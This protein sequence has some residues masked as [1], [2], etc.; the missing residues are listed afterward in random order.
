AAD[1]DAADPDAADP[2]AA[3][4][5]A[6]DPDAADPDAADPDAV[7]AA[8]PHAARTDAVDET[9]P[10]QPDAVDPD[11]ANA[12]APSPADSLG[13]R[14]RSVADHATHE[15]HTDDTN[16]A[17]HA[18]HANYADDPVA[19]Q[20]FGP[21]AASRPRAGFRRWAVASAIVVVLA[22]AVLVV[23]GAFGQ[24]TTPAEPEVAVP[25]RPDAAAA[26]DASIGK[27]QERLRRLPKDYVTWASLG[28]AYIEKA[29]IT[30]D[31][32]WYPKA[33]GALKQSLAVRPSP[34]AAAL[35]GLGAL[36]NARHDFATARTRAREALAQNP[37]SAD[38][39]GVLADA[40][41]QLGHS[42]AATDAIQGMLDLRPA[43]AALT[44]GS[45]DL[46]QHGQDQEAE[47][48]M[49]QA[50]HSAVDPADVAFCRYQLGELAWK[51]GNLAAA[52][53]EYRSGLEADPDYLALHQGQAKVAAA[54]GN[55]NEAIAEYK[56]LTERS[57]T[58]TYLI[59]YAEYL[60]AAGRTADAAQQLSL[61]EAASRLFAANGGTDD[62]STV[63][64]AL[65]RNQPADAL[66]AAQREWKRRQ[67]SDVAD[68]MAETLHANGRDAEALRYADRAVALGVQS[69]RF[70]YHRG[71]IEAALGRPAE[72]RRDLTAAL[73]LNPHFSP[74]DAPAARRAL[75]YL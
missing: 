53:R 21:S 37:Y 18:I 51:Y 44:R 32:S 19:S 61:A 48:L 58:P 36:A 24:P 66:A 57:P 15:T 49:R 22:I 64:L 10:A 9:L 4:P 59:E 52:T 65:A 74:V 6:A 5:D 50:L 2:D 42:D 43:L 31:P 73:K 16:H 75:A 69:A 27:A 7:D 14:G 47:K 33:E 56:T 34:N 55:L 26:L 70:L 13:V 71:V 8:Q 40:E 23:G 54:N 45:Y 62:L 68:A 1:P 35:T 38:A 72:A 67:F 30:A 3:D 46:E 29:R 63:A 12:A 11:R 28:G 25:A 39:F 17:D 60:T 41:T 20:P